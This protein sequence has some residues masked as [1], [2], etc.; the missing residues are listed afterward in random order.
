M[1]NYMMTKYASIMFIF[2]LKDLV[3]FRLEERE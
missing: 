1:V 3:V 2:E